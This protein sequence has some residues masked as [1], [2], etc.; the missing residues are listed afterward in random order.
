MGGTISGDSKHLVNSGHLIA[1]TQTNIDM[2][3][4]EITN[5]CLPG[6]LLSEQEDTSVEEET[7]AIDSERIL[8]QKES[9]MNF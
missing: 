1:D 6:G 5:F 3:C 8:G 9:M 4:H 2:P 7:Q